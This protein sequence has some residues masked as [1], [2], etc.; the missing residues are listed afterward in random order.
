VG[1]EGS[2]KQGLI[3]RNGDALELKK[4]ILLDEAIKAYKD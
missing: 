2:K 4:N 3:V 1:Y